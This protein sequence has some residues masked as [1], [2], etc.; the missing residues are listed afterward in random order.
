MRILIDATCISDQMCGWERYSYNL[1]KEISLIDKENE[2]TVLLAKSDLS[3]SHEVFELGK[4]KNFLLKRVG[5]KS[6]GP[7]REFKFLFAGLSPDYDLF[8]CLGNYL[9][10]FQNYRSVVTIHDLGYV[11]YSR[12][13]GRV[14]SLKII[15]MKYI[16]K[17]A[18]SK[19]KRIIADSRATKQE[20]IDILGIPEEKIGVI[21]LAAGLRPGSRPQTAASVLEKYSIKKPYFLHLGTNLPHKNL[22]GLIEAFAEFKKIHDRWDARLVIAGKQHPQYKQHLNKAGKLGISDR[23]IFTGFVPKEHIPPLYREAAAF[24]FLS[25]HEGFGLPI[26]EAMECGTPVIS[27]GVSSMPEV[28]ADAAILVSPEKPREIAQG[29]FAILDSKELRRK[30]IEKGHERLKQFSWRKTA[31]ETLKVYREVY[32]SE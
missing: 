5:F 19:A 24:L 12:F 18:F 31:E 28:T 8:H 27:S 17:K 9:P 23:L 26:L 13:C 22:N 7:M 29:M 6:A 4:R 11:G 30:Y 25:F 16:F 14:T 2:Y 20:V 32:R 3:D 21:Y 10:I 1:M 15:Y